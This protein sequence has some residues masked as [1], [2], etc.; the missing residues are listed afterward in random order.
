MSVLAAAVGAHTFVTDDESLE[1]MYADG[2]T[3]PDGTIVDAEEQLENIYERVDEEAGRGESLSAALDRL[4]SGFLDD[5]VRRWMTSAYT[6]FDN[7]A[8]LDDLSGQF[9]DEDSVFPGDDVILTGG[10]DQVLAP[11]ANGVDVRFG[12]RVRSVR[13]LEEEGVEVTTDQGAFRAMYVICTC[14]LGVLKQGQVTFDPPLPGSHARAMDRMGMGNV[15]K[16]ALKFDAPFWPVDTQYLGLV[17]EPPGRWNYFLNYRTFTDQ[18]MLVGLSVGAYPLVAEAMS[19]AE[20]VADAM[21]VL[22]DAYGDAVPDPIAFRTTRWSENPNSYGA[23]SYSRAG[24]S[25]D[26]WETLAEPV[27]GTLLFAGEHTCWDN[28]GTTHGAL[29]SGR[30]AARWII[31]DA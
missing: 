16:I 13:L 15:T 31:D 8:A 5:A 28:K 21:L 24:S 30:A 18:N 9:F 2:E 25:P 11:L 14:P 1:V 22:R 20:M 27:D 12:Q 6:E 23:Y 17:T 19:D 10:Y 26:D 3:V 29:L 4:D 7:G